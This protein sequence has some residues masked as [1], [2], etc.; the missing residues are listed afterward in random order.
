MDAEF[1]SQSFYWNERKDDYVLLKVSGD[2]LNSIDHCLIYNAKEHYSTIIE[3]DDLE[4]R[5]MRKMQDAGVPIVKERPPG[6]NIVARMIN[7]M[8]EA[9]RP[10]REINA[11]IK[12]HQR[13]HPE[14]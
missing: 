9:G 5:I 8:L 14:T 13:L 2:D 12:E 1:E 3:D 7:D 11:A 10:P 4:V 6:E